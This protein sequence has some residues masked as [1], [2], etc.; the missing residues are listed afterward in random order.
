[1]TIGIKIFL[2]ILELLF[3]SVCIKSKITKQ[4]YCDLHTLSKILGYQIYAN[5]E[6]S[7]NSYITW[8]DYQY[9]VLLVDD[10]IRVT[11]VQFMK[12]KS[13]IF[14]VFYDFVMIL[15]RQYNIQV[16]VLHTNFGE[17]NFDAV[18]EYWNHTSVLWELSTLYV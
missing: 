17:F 11:W 15:E 6:G 12:K 5:V 16:C 3:C 18:L 10:V 4:L 14:S 13:D 1:M 9:F 2:S 8:K 7:A